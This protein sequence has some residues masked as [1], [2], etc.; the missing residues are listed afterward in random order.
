MTLTFNVV[1]FGSGGV[2]K[3]ALTIR[4]ILGNFIEKYDPTIEDNYRKLVNIGDGDFYMLDI[5]DTAGTYQFQPMRDLYMRNKDG[6]VIVYSIGELCTFE[7][8]KTICESILR[9][10]YHRAVI[11]GEILPIVIIGNKSD[12]QNDDRMVKFEDGFDYTQSLENCLFFETS[13]KLGINIEQPFVELVKTMKRASL[14]KKSNGQRHSSS[15][16]FLF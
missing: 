15:R 11:N 4:F 14:N 7:Y 5:L 2:G 10:N 8:M 9:C 13:A 1:I 3:S 16:C 12:L 6:Y